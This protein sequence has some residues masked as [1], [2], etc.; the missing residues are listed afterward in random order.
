LGIQ[1]SFA[2][3][4]HSQDLLPF[5]TICGKVLLSLYCN[6]RLYANGSRVETQLTI[7][8][9]SA[10]GQA[11]ILGVACRKRGK[12]KMFHVKDFLSGNPERASNGIA[13]AVV[14]PVQPKLC[15]TDP[16]TEEGDLPHFSMEKGT[17]SSTSARIL[18]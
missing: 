7:P 14:H 2:Y 10:S 18:R 1:K 16:S 6:F 12:R 9:K 5:I 8:T 3:C 4:N 11:G 13:G 15:E 17:I